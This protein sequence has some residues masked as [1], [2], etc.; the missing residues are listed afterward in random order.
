MIIPFSEWL[1]V[2]VTFSSPETIRLRGVDV[3]ERF[4]KEVQYHIKI[5]KLQFSIG[6]YSQSRNSSIFLPSFVICYIKEW[7]LL[8]AHTVKPKKY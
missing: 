7:S 8:V 1:N 2:F 3:T 4:N 6:K 5:N